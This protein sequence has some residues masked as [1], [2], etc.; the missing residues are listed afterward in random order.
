MSKIKIY[1]DIRK[2]KTDGSKEAPLM[3]AVTHRGRTA[4]IPF[5]ISIPAAFWDNKNGKV[6]KHPQRM[7]FNDIIYK[8]L[9]EIER[10]FILL[11]EEGRI[12]NKMT[13][14]EI[15]DRLVE[16]T[17]SED[18]KKAQETEN[19]LKNVYTRFMSHKTGGTL[20]LYTATFHRLG[21]YLGKDFDTLTFEMIDKEWLTCWDEHLAKTSPSANSRSIHLRNLRA[22]FNDAIDNGITTNYPFRRFKIKTQK[23]KKRNLKVDVL[24]NLFTTTKLEPWM[25]KYRDFFMLSFMLCGINVGDLCKL[26]EIKDGRIEYIRAKTHK[27]YSIK[28]EPEALEIINRYKGETHLLNYLDT[29]K[30]YRIFYNRLCVGLRK[31]K[32]VIGIPELS[33]YWARHSWATIAASIDIPK[34]TIAQ[35]LGHGGNTVTDIYLELDQK[36]VDIANR[37]VLD[38]VLYNKL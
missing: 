27:P 38:W 8:R 12:N 23:T 11:S 30:D 7:M 9:L 2:M 18:V 33:S 25:E 10:Q 13:A 26:K 3:I 21:D 31:L 4:Y 29:C 17:I 20:A 15:R 24:R 22:V 28:L 14:V 6:I 1:H 5:Y 35:G 16:A 32:D 36:K 37:K 19:F 34:D